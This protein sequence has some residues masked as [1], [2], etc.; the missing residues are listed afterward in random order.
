[1]LGLAADWNDCINLK[2]KGESIWSTFLYY[3]ALTE[4]IE[5]ARRTGKDADVKLF[6]ERRAEIKELIDTHAWDGEWFLRGYLDSGRKLGGRESEQSKIFLNSQS[7]AVFSG[8]AT[9][10]KA[11]MALDSMHRYLV[12]EHGIVLNH[13]AYRETDNE[14]GAITSFPGGLKENAG[15]FCHA[16]TWAVI[17]ECL[18]GRGDKAFA[19]YTSFLPAAKND[20]AD[21][22]TMEPYVYAQFITGI[23]HQ[24]HFGRARNSWLTGTA[25]WSFVA[26]SQYIL[27][28]RPDYDGLVIDPCIPAEW[29]GFEATRICRGKTFR[30]KVKNPSRTGYGVKELKVNGRVLP[31]NLI[32]YAEAAEEN[33]VE[34]TL[35]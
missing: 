23:D 7:W 34:V 18:L 1:M 20:R 6:T 5:L 14:I 10:E 35:G 13:P 28:I 8:A 9:G 15:I 24:Y 4:F 26:V 22:Y 29:D 16:N 27:G 25:A 19:L 33:E 12:T 17:A 30:I 2:G 21:L 3:R 11:R 32:P 31:G